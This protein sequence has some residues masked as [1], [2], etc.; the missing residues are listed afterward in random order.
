MTTSYLEFAAI[1]ELQVGIQGSDS[2]S[3]VHSH[4]NLPNFW[5]PLIKVWFDETDFTVLSQDSRTLR[6]QPYN[7]LILHMVKNSYAK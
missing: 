4:N 2:L 3:T 6:H 1:Y 5:L 7:L